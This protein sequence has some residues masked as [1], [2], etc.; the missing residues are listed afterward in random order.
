[1]LRIFNPTLTLIM[2]C[3]V[4]FY[5]NAMDSFYKDLLP[6][7]NIEGNNIQNIKICFVILFN[8]KKKSINKGNQTRMVCIVLNSD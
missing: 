7:G 3:H 2:F 8:R 6:L 1:M 5:K 4:S